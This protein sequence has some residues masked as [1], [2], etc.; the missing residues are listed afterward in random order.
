MEGLR[1]IAAHL[2]GKTAAGR[3]SRAGFVGDASE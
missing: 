1:E 3:I 2:H